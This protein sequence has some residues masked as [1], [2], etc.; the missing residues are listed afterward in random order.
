MEIDS[1]LNKLLQFRDSRNW[2]RF[3]TPKN[4]SV[5]LSVETSEICELFL[6]VD[7]AKSDEVAQNRRDE[8]TSEMADVFIYLLYLAER[9][10][11]DLVSATEEKIRLNENRFPASNLG[12]LDSK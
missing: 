1:L 11:I 4:L 8:L 12:D 10:G 9:T 2:S 6:W 7:S 3:H 5:A